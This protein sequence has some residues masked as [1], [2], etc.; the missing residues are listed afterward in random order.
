ML[1]R[2]QIGSQIIGDAW[3]Y[4]RRHDYFLYDS[5]GT[6]VIGVNPEFYTYSPDPSNSNYDFNYNI[7]SFSCISATNR[8]TNMVPNGGCNPCD[9]GCLQGSIFGGN[10]YSGCASGPRYIAL[11]P[12]HII[13]VDHYWAVPS[14]IGTKIKFYSSNEDQWQKAIFRKRFP[15]GRGSVGVPPNSPN[16]EL[17]ILEIQAGPQGVNPSDD[18]EYTTVL[19]DTVFAPDVEIKYPFFM[20]RI[21]VGK[22]PL[23]KYI[24]Q[25]MVGFLIDQDMRCHVTGIKIESN[26]PSATSISI[27]SVAINKNEDGQVNLK[28]L[29]D[30]NL[31]M[32]VDGGGSGA[33]SGDSGSGLFTHDRTLTEDSP[34]LLGLLSSGGSSFVNQLHEYVIDIVKDYDI[35]NGTNYASDLVNRILTREQFDIDEYSYDVGI[36]TNNISAIDLNPI[37]ENEEN[38]GEAEGTALGEFLDD[39]NGFIIDPAFNRIVS[40]EVKGDNSLEWSQSSWDVSDFNLI[41]TN[42]NNYTI[43]NGNIY[44]CSKTSTIYGNTEEIHYPDILPGTVY[45]FKINSNKTIDYDGRLFAPRGVIEIGPP[46]GDDPI[47]NPIEYFGHSITS[48]STSIFISGGVSVDLGMNIGFDPWDPIYGHPNPSVVEYKMINNEFVLQQKIQPDGFEKSEELFYSEMFGN[49]MAANDDWLFVGNNTIGIEEITNSIYV[50]NKD[51]NGQWVQHQVIETPFF[52]NTDFDASFGFNLLVEDKMLLISSERYK[53]AKDSTPMGG[54][55]IYELNTQTGMW[56]QKSL[57]NNEHKKEIYDQVDQT[58]VFINSPLFGESIDHSAGIIAVSAPRSISSLSEDNITFYDDHSDINNIELDERTGSVSI[59]RLNSLTGIWDLTLTADTLSY[60]EYS[61]GKSV[62]LKTYQDEYGRVYKSSIISLEDISDVE[63]KGLKDLYSGGKIINITY[64]YD[65]FPLNKSI[66]KMKGLGQSFNTKLI[67]TFTKTIPFINT[68]TSENGI[69][70]LPLGIH[71]A[72]IEVFDKYTKITAPNKKAI[73][74]M[75]QNNVDELEA[76]YLREVLSKM[77]QDNPGTF[78]GADKSNITNGMANNSV[79]IGI[80]NNQTEEESS[81]AQF[82]SGEFNLNIATINQNDIYINGFL[83]TNETIATLSEALY[84]YGIYE[85]NSAIKT[86]LNLA[87]IQAEGIDSFKPDIPDYISQAQKD[88]MESIF[89]PDTTDDEAK[90]IRYF[91]LGSEVYYGLWEHDP[92]GDGTSGNNEYS[93]TSRSQMQSEDPDLYSIINGFFPEDITINY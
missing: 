69:V 27:S 28:Y 55:F 41:D 77:L 83:N 67:P 34:I 71:P 60:P 81:D 26:K 39:K 53:S 62:S 93:I 88:N 56:L 24:I 61:F 57:I 8:K 23:K 52:E 68:S 54:V 87:R 7:P 38:K 79:I 36:K 47:N 49:S 35:E 82:L 25:N 37:W 17:T 91:A 22:D 59:Y 5:N 64:K 20:P 2:H 51:S 16:G 75:I 14:S 43:F 65:T 50:F 74:I 76:V 30:N 80:F 33:V 15:I 44:F 3:Y 32:L 73:H 92:N 85:N 31:G 4:P 90:N 84:R 40:F 78:Y 66:S 89:H 63:T 19:G 29:Q 6:S 10:P 42:K 13:S 12:A 45:R 58:S 86:A 70:A 18:S 21:E 9:D 48:N 1:F 11:T 46:I 72:Y